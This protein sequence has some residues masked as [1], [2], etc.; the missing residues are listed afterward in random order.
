MENEKKQVFN[1]LGFQEFNMTE[2]S[3]FDMLKDY[4][5]LC[6]EEQNYKNLAQVVEN[7]KTI[8]VPFDNNGF[9]DSCNIIDF[10]YDH[11][12][13][14]LYG[15]CNVTLCSAGIFTYRFSIYEYISK[16]EKK[17]I[18][19]W[20]DIVR[21]FSLKDFVFK[22]PITIYPG[23]DKKFYAELQT[24]F[25]SF[26]YN[27]IR[28]LE[29]QMD[30]HAYSS[31]KNIVQNIEILHPHKYFDFS[32]PVR[33]GYQRASVDED[34]RIRMDY[35]YQK[36]IVNENNDQRMMIPMQGNATMD[37]KVKIDTVTKVVANIQCEK[38]G[39]LF[40]KADWTENLLVSEHKIEW[41][42]EDWNN[43]LPNSAG[44]SD[45]AVRLFLRIDFSTQD[46]EDYSI[47]VASPEFNEISDRPYYKKIPFLQIYWGC[48]AKGSLVC[49]EDGS[50]KFIEEIKAGDYVRTGE[51]LGAKV[52]EVIEGTEEYIYHLKSFGGHRI[53]ATGEHPIATKD[54][55]IK[56][57]D[58]K[59]DTLLRLDDGTMMLP[60]YCYKELYDDKVYSL[61]LENADNFCC[62][63]FISGT[64]SVQGNLTAYTGE[65]EFNEY[66]I[67]VMDE[68]E[69]AFRLL[70]SRL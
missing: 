46:A 61:E 67:K 54:G 57:K 18:K 70:Q 26:Q 8:K 66:Q 68:F 51:G 50:E 64:H 12:K 42:Y 17:H 1:G 52:K 65:L 31:S 13:K 9:V 58:I 53:L 49:M 30:I 56:V 60:F 14:M 24:T 15:V 7:T 3:N 11:L 38:Y 27:T 19:T 69:E 43:Y 6:M 33:I 47:I 28:V 63:G 37:T 22:T 21:G 25:L 40:F 2:K 23:E 44:F 41:L 36:K 20:K 29:S 4:K 55:F 62:D 45:V 39:T 10:G 16:N 34:R 32:A 35:Y 59:S 48:L 5:N